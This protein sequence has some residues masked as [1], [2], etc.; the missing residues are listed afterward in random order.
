MR[1]LR[2]KIDN[3]FCSS[4]HGHARV[5]H[6]SRNTNFRGCLNSVDEKANSIRGHIRRQEDEAANYISFAKRNT[7]A[8]SSRATVHQSAFKSR[9]E[10][11]SKQQK[12]I[13]SLLTRRYR[14]SHIQIDRIPHTLPCWLQQWPSQDAHDP[15]LLF[16]SLR[17]DTRQNRTQ[18]SLEPTASHLMMSES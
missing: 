1:H 2:S 11:N 3:D 8:I 5:V 15:H 14:A 17:K 6:A 18:T 9:G 12:K 10:L 7:T 4:I 13:L 16:W